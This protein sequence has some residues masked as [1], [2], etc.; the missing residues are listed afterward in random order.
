MIAGLCAELSGVSE[1]SL[2]TVSIIVLCSAILTFIFNFFT[3]EYSWTDRLWSTLPIYMAWLYYFK[4]QN[5]VLLI[6]A[7]LVTVWGLRL[8]FNFSRK[9]GFN[10]KEDYRW[11]YLRNKLGSGFVWQIFSLL[12][13]A[14]YQ[15]AL[16]IGFTSPFYLISESMVSN[17][18][19]YVFAILAILFLV[20]ET[21][22]DQQQW[23][24][25]EEKYGRKKKELKFEK[26]FT[27]GFRT[28]GLFSISRHPN[29]LGELGFWWS[30]YFLCSTT[31][32]DLVNLTA[33]G[34]VLLTLLFIGSVSFTEGI[35]RNKYKDYDWYRKKVSAV[36]PLFWKRLK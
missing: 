11:A 33:I 14:F 19:T 18:L 16:F 31:V 10:E 32:G 20:L 35:S 2:V 25:Q 21:I 34:P 7:L 6:T 30:I 12:F 17:N 36:F 29:Y 24:F 5:E 22:A 1:N 3:K 15:Q 4:V 28:S 13:I 27:Q 23:V 26:E 8:T 9:G